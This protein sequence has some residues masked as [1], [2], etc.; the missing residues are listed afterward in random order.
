MISIIVNNLNKKLSQKYPMLKAK[1]TYN[2][3][4]IIVTFYNPAKLSIRYEC[5][6]IYNN[7]L[8]SQEIMSDAINRY[9]Y[10]ILK[11]YFN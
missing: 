6:Y 3:K 10:F 9:R 2:D 11:K 4:Y 5:D 8:S 7:C 1:V